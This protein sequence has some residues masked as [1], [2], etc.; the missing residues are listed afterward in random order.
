[1][2]TRMWR[3]WAAMVSQD[4]AMLCLELGWWEFSTLREKNRAALG[5]YGRLMLLVL[6]WNTEKIPDRDKQ[7]HSVVYRRMMIPLVQ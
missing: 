2:K 3:N 4:G 1:M 5:R 6:S 7:L